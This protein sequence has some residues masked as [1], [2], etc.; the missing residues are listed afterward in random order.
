[1]QSK[2]AL[3]S[4]LNRPPFPSS[5][6]Q[7]LVAQKAVTTRQSRQI[8]S[9][10]GARRDRISRKLRCETWWGRQLGIVKIALHSGG[11]F[12]LGVQHIFQYDIID[13]MRPG[14]PPCTIN[15]EI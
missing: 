5:A 1:M 15:S 7:L 11:H 9:G 14:A 8:V 2:E 12:F 6:K 13:M 4:W 10:P 3:F